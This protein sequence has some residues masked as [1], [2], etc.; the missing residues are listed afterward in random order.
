MCNVMYS[1][2]VSYSF[3]V[4]DVSRA[5]FTAVPRKQVVIKGSEISLQCLVSGNPP[6]KV[7]WRRNGNPITDTF[8]TVV[9]SC[10]EILNV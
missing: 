7:E 6:P 9:F 1:H 8:R 2:L 4:S 10:F 3:P 5:H